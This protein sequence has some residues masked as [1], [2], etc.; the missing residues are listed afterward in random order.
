MAQSSDER[1]SGGGR[2]SLVDLG[3]SCIGKGEHLKMSVSPKILFQPSDRSPVAIGGKL[4][5]L[6]GAITI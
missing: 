6:E 3:H 5:F 2:S 1:H 4:F